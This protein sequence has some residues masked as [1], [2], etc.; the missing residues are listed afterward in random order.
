MSARRWWLRRDGLRYV[1]QVSLRPQADNA[2]ADLGGTPEIGAAPPAPAAGL[3]RAERA[4]AR[5][6]RTTGART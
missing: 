2:M 3:S 1:A 4:A 6:H 5:A